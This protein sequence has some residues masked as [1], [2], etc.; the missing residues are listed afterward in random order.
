MNERLSGNERKN[1]RLSS[2]MFEILLNIDY[3]LDPLSV[4]QK[5]ARTKR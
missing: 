5:L 1:C 3:W 2:F 4:H